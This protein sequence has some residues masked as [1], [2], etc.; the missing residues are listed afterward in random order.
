MA[1]ALFRFNTKR[2]ERDETDIRHGIGIHTGEVLAGNVGSDQRK[3]YAMLGDTVNL[4]SRLQ[5]LTKSLD[6]HILIS[7][8][9]RARLENKALRLQ[10]LGRHSLRGKAEPVEVY[11][12]AYPAP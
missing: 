3:T 5:V 1:R 2:R 7:Q 6:T 9:T 12:V 11:A 10:P 8:A 4:A